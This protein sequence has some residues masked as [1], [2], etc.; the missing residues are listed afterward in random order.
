MPW[1]ASPRSIPE[2]APSSYG[3]F[4]FAMA[5]LVIAACSPIASEAAGPPYT[6]I[7][8]AGRLGDPGHLDGQGTQAQVHSTNH[9][10][11]DGAGNLYI[12]ESGT[13]RQISPAGEVRTLAGVARSYL[14]L[15][16]VGTEARFSDYEFPIAADHAGNVYAVDRLRHT[17]RKM[18]PRGE[19]TTFAGRQNISG[20]EDGPGPAARFNSP[21]GIVVDSAGFIYVS[22]SLNR[23]IRRISPTGEVSTVTV[24]G[25]VSHLAWPMGLAIDGRD[26]IYVADADPQFIHTINVLSPDGTLFRTR[27]GELGIRPSY[28]YFESD[29]INFRIDASG[30][31]LVHQFD[32]GWLRRLTPEAIETDRFAPSSRAQF[33]SN[34]QN[35]LAIDRDGV[36]F[37]FEQG[38]IKRRILAATAKRTPAWT[39]A[40]QAA[41]HTLTGVAYGNGT[42][43]IAGNPGRQPGP[44]APLIS[45]SPDGVAWTSRRT[46]VTGT[47]MALHYVHDRFFLSVQPSSAVANGASQVAVGA[48][49]LTSA[50][51]TDWRSSDQI[52]LQGRPV[53]APEDFAYG[54]GIYVAVVKATALSPAV[55]LSSSDGLPWTARAIDGTSGIGPVRVVYFKDRFF[56]LAPVQGRAG[57]GLYSS[58]DAVAWSAVPTAPSPLHGIAASSAVLLVTLAQEHESGAP[59]ATTTDGVSFSLLPEQAAGYLGPGVRYANYAFMTMGGTTPDSDVSPDAL[60]IHASHDGQ[61]WST[62]GSIARPTSAVVGFAAVAGRHVV[63][64]AQGVYSGL[65]DFA[66]GGQPALRR[67]GGRLNHVSVLARI[68][69]VGEPLTVGITLAETATG[70]SGGLLLRGIGP[71]LSQFGVAAVSDP[72]I[73]WLSGQ[74]VLASN[75]DWSGTPDLV[76]ATAA[77]GAFPL[78][79]GSQDAALVLPGVRPGTY[80]LQVT[81]ADRGPRVALAE[82]HDL[83]RLPAAAAT[84]GRLSNLSARAL[85]SPGGERLIAGFE[86]AGGPARVLI[87]AIGPTLGQFDVRSYLGDPWL[88]V[89]R[90]SV[91][92]AANDDWHPATAPEPLQRRAGAF[93]LPVRS[94]DAAIA[95]S[96]PPGT[97]T[98]HVGG[99]GADTGVAL[100]EVFEIP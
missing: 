36:I 77:A 21:A 64:T 35:L 12:S 3:S 61:T 24:S 99:A 34:G 59:G 53:D 79:A 54:N 29:G 9:A 8:L 72:R 88:E 97:Y 66:P 67:P 58:P 65:T 87:R 33:F 63:A 18:T 30:N 91:L 85:V 14:Y 10:C 96:L 52:L 16:G 17:V 70:G 50:N 22:D 49:I 40:W 62:V 2:T 4:P 11:L 76:Q 31:L 46:P 71:A 7:P 39:Q 28:P 56:A 93:G 15:D 41:D 6:D 19:V 95:T 57:S 37:L 73:A 92:V 80:A 98:V 1:L 83:T 94:R 100:V 32:D 69:G 45:T 23:A 81:T 89:Y 51:G 84:A 75:D 27:W 38:V 48:S 90:G 20:L 26:T 47:A 74:T 42:F 5:V 68:D 25:A 44:Q 55:I 78:P 86:V 60:V 82:V 13:I 43:V